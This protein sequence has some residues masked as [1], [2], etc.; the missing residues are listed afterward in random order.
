MHALKCVTDY[1]LGLLTLRHPAANLISRVF[2]PIFGVVF[3]HAWGADPWILSVPKAMPQKPAV[4]TLRM[5]KD[6]LKAQNIR[7][8]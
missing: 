2:F 1:C 5:L 8:L 6:C 7:C 3:G 4:H